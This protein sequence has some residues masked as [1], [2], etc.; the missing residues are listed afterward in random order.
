VKLGICFS[1]ERDGAQVFSVF[2]IKKKK[3]IWVCEEGG[4]S[5]ECIRRGNW[6]EDTL[7]LGCLGYLIGLDRGS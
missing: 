4:K 1:A 2:F 7:G 3:Q 5:E 6:I